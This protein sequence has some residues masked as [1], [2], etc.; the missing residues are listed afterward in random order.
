MA[1]SKPMTESR[2]NIGQ[3][4]Q[5]VT[6]DLQAYYPK[7]VL[8][9]GSAARLLNGIG[10]E[11]APNDI[12]MI[13]VGNNVPFQPMNRSYPFPL[14]LHHVRVHRIVEIA[15][16]LRY[17]PKAVALSKL[18]G[19][20]LARQ[21]SINIIIA[22]MLLGKAYNDFGIEQ[23]AVGNTLDAR[24]YSFHRVLYGENWWQ[25]LTRYARERRG[26]LGRFS[27]KVVKRYEFDPT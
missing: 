19:A 7:T 14:E 27:D 25:E 2:Q 4:V 18:Y 24:D 16:T 9:F 20:T 23:I 8:L 11:D 10:G 21:H 15:R 12:D 13:F 6:D 1:G 3:V 5:E 17:D 26:V 22:A